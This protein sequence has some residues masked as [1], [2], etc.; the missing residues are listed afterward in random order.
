MKNE[1]GKQYEEDG[2]FKASAR[3]HQSKYRANMLKVDFDEY[4]NRI[5]DQD[6]IRL[7]N[8]YPRLNVRS[9][10]R[11]RFPSYSKERDADMLR[12]EHIPFNFFA[13]FVF[14]KEL[15]RQMIKA[16]FEIKF[17]SIHEIKFEYAPK[18]KVDYLD[19]G[20]SFDIY[21]EYL[22]LKNE[23]SGIGIEVKYTEKDYSIGKTEKVNVENLESNYWKVTNSSGAFHDDSKSALIT[24]PMRQI[25]RNHLLGL[26]MILRNEIEDF[27]SI[28]L[29]PLGNKHY[30]HIIPE[31]QS[32]LRKPFRDQVRGCTYEKFIG[33]INGRDEVLKWKDYLAQRYLV[34]A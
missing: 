11:K 34:T 18:P 32:L 25:W 1:I 13:P 15:G 20:T 14:D 22:D 5:I 2:V 8:Y 24:D 12:S 33:L 10:L 26:S 27:T 19:D 3:L 31:Y 4:G 16:A 9:A 17:K 30:H 28:I 21:I 29:Y 6:A 23:V 7:L